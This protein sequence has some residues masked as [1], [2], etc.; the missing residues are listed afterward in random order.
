[1]A[2]DL[3]NGFPLLTTKKMF[4]RGIVEELLFFIRGDTDTSMLSD[5][6]VRIWE[7]NTTEDFLKSK[8]LEYSNGVMGPMYGYQW[9]YFNSPYVLDENKKPIRPNGG[10]DQLKQIVE[11]IN[12]DPNS[13]RIIMTTYNPEQANEGVLYPCHSLMIQ[14]YV[15][16][17]YLDMFCYNRSQDF[18]LGTPYNIASSSILLTLV[19]KITG[20]IPR[21]LNIT[22]GDVHIYKEHYDA[23]KTQIE[24][25]AYKFPNLNIDKNITS[26]DDLNSLTFEDFKLDNYN[27]NEIIKAQMKT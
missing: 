23:V 8:N 25:T 16:D 27:S 26:V 2:F 15:D 14:F 7:G 19:S 24:N 21:K 12:N 17:K 5:K 22:M 18:F 4:F 6:K 10:V 3:T 13:R 11:L 20:K 9:R 1:M